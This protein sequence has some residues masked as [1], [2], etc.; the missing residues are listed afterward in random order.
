MKNQSQICESHLMVIRV[1]HQWN[2]EEEICKRFFAVNLPN[3]LAITFYCFTLL[4][5][6]L[7]LRSQKIFF[8][9]GRLTVIEENNFHVAMGWSR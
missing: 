1:S 4:G 5:R 2:A 9:H 6:A 8:R 3:P 7:T